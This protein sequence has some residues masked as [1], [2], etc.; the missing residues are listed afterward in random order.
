MCH[1]SQEI[2]FPD[3]KILPNAFLVHPAPK[4]RLWNKAA[5]QSGI[6]SAQINAPARKGTNIKTIIHRL[7]HRMIILSVITV[8]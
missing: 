4:V 7:F 2:H 8:K 1:V 3:I 6:L 5:C